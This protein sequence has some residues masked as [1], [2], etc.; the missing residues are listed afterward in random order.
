MDGGILTITGVTDANGREIGGGVSQK[1]AQLYGR[2]EARV[3]VVGSGPASAVVLLWPKTEKWPAD[4]EIDM[5]EARTPD[6]QSALNYLH[7]QARDYKAGNT[8]HADFSQWHTIAVDWSPRR[9][10]FWLDSVQVWSSPNAGLVP[11]TSPMHLALQVDPIC[12]TGCPTAP[13]KLQVDWIKTF[14]TA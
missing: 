7:N 14:A 3:R 1:H 10:T 2:W 5:L 4:G 12:S 9:A 13:T 8:M 11:S 6:R